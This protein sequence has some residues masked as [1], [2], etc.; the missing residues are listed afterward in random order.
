MGT[1]KCNDGGKHS[2]DEQLDGL[3]FILA[4]ILIVS[5]NVIVNSRAFFFMDPWIGR[6]GNHS[7]HLLMGHLARMQT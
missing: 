3:E 5:S 6:L 7:L 2:M 1:G 4:N